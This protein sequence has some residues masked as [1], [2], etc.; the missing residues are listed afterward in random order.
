MRKWDIV[1]D[2]TVSVVKVLCTVQYTVQLWRTSALSQLFVLMCC[3]G[4]A[5]CTVGPRGDRGQLYHAAIVTRR[6]LAV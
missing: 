6:I 1:Y 5:R 4:A 2:V 3:T